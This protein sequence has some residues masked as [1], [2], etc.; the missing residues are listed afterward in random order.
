M[1]SFCCYATFI[2]VCL[3]LVGLLLF[4]CVKH[5]RIIA[6]Y[7][8]K[9]HIFRFIVNIA[10]PFIIPFVLTF[11]IEGEKAYSLWQKR[12]FITIIIVACINTAAQFYFWNKDRQ[13]VNL[14][15]ENKA[16]KYAYNNLYEICT[17][18]NNQL[19]TAYH[20]GMKNGTV[21]SYS[22]PYDIFNHIR[23]ITWEFCKTISEITNIPTKDLDASFIYRYCYP[24]IKSENSWRW[25]TG[26]GSKFSITLDDFIYEH[27]S[28]FHY[29]INNNIS[30]MFYNDKEEARMN[31]RYQMTY[32]D[33]SH[34]QTGSFV[35]AKVAFSGND[36][37]LCEGIIMINSYGKK[38]LDDN[39]E[40]SE[41]EFRHLILDGI[42]PCYRQ[43]LSNELAML[44]FRH[45]EQRKD[46]RENDN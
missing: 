22:M 13:E 10:L 23:K 46:T 2:L 44:Y 17:D 20:I 8:K 36:Q 15:W 24:G 35:A 26:K 33:F 21:D 11:L 30:M 45:K 42:F 5:R 34:K 32:K 3:F 14:K 29:L 27:D 6:R 1:R 25:I 9:L 41:D 16:S 37:C 31:Q 40:Y 4:L 12:S 7:I 19:R 39:P 43:L 28:T 18:K 38:F